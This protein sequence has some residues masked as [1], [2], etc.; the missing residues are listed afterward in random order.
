[1]EDLPFLNALRPYFEAFAEADH[2]RRMELLAEAMSP[3]AQIWGPKRVFAGYR[4]I[5]EKITGFREN[6]PECRLVLATGLNTFLNAARFGSSIVD[7]RGAVMASGHAV[8]ELA[9]D[10]R[11]Y[12]VIPFWETLPPLPD[13]WPEHLASQSADAEQVGPIEARKVAPLKSLPLGD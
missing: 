4:E 9:A 13:A 10:G 1:M 6:W 2:S 12:R 7:R 3:E 5:S 11:I 8:V